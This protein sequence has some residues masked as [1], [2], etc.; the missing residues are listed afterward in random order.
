MG[1]IIDSLK[2]ELEQKNATITFNNLGSVPIIRFQFKQVLENI[3]ENALKFY[4]PETKPLIIINGAHVKYDENIKF[5]YVMPIDY[6]HISICDNGIGFDNDYKNKIFDLFQRLNNK[7]DYDGTG[8]GL[9]MA[10]KIIENHNGF[11]NA[12][13]ELAKGATFNIYIPTKQD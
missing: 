2:P 12:T 1:E 6:Y 13:G 11:I 5:N 4:N 3:I 10:R 7:E 9:T 8:I